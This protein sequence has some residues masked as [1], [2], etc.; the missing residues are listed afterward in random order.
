LEQAI[1]RLLAGRTA[2]IIAHRL[3]TVGR[4][5]QILILEGGRA[6]EFG[7]RRA[8]AAAPDSH[9]ASLLRTGLEEALV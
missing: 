8:L 3:A 5:D 2:I 7:P 1:D 6:L 4:A 9:F